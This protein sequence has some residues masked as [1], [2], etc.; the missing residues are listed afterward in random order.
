MTVYHDIRNIN[1]TAIVHA[2]EEEN[3]NSE[4]N[5][6]LDFHDGLHKIVEERLRALDF[7]SHGYIQGSNTYWSGILTM[8]PFDDLYDRYD[9]EEAILND[10]K[11]HN[12]K[13]WTTPDGLLV[14]FYNPHTSPLYA[15][16]NE[17]KASGYGGNIPYSIE[18]LMN[19]LE[20]YLK[21]DIIENTEVY[22]TWNLALPI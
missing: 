12:L 22:G 5:W 15:F 17:Y 18:G 2:L 14:S 8:E 7:H 1:I 10:I 21:Q 19:N 13:V 9:C 20:R 6:V 16:F 11:D 4:D 3:R